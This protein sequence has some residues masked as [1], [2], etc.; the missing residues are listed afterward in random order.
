MTSSPTSVTA[1]FREVDNIAFS[2][3]HRTYDSEAIKE[4]LIRQQALKI[5]AAERVRKLDWE[6]AATKEAVVVMTRL[7]PNARR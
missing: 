3:A 7:L 5:L 1:H 6:L 2:L 4:H